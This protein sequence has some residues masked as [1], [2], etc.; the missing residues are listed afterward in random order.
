MEFLLAILGVGA[1]A[2]GLI[3][4]RYGSLVVGCTI[5]ILFG[6]VFTRDFWQL[7]F[8]PLPLT[9]DRLLIAGLAVLFAWRW[10]RGGIQ[11]RPLTGAD[12]LAAL[13]VGY[14]TVRCVLTE[15]AG[16]V[17]SSVSPSW[18]LIASFL[19][20]AALY[21]IV[22]N[23]E[24]EEK[25]WKWLL[26]G[27]SILGLYL[28]FTGIAEV[29]QQWWAVF[30]SF[31]SDPKL[32]TH[33]G[34]A[35]GP[36]LMSASLGV[37]LAVCFWASWFLWS[38]VNRWWRVL[39]S[40]SMLLMCAALYYTY[41][42]SC[43][44]GL[45]AGLA[46]VPLLHFP[47]SWRP[48]VLA[49]LIIGVGFGGMFVGSKV[50]NMGRKDADGDAEHSVYQRASFIYVSMRMFRDDPVFGCGF[51]RFYDK[52]MP[53]LSDRSQQI[54]LESI[55]KLD[56]HNTFLSILTETGIVGFTL[57]LATLVAWTRAAWQLVANPRSPRWVRNHG[58]FALAILIVY[59]VNALFHDLTLSPSEQWILCLIS[60][61]AVGLQSMSR[62]AIASEAKL[63][64]IVRI[65]EPRGIKLALQPAG[66]RMLKQVSLFGMKIHAVE[67]NTAV[68][69]VLSWCHEPAK[70]AC[71]YVV[72]PNVDHTVM[73]QTRAD[74][75]HAYAGAA[76]VLADGAPV[77]WASRL[78]R[79]PLPERVAGSDLVPA[80]FDAANQNSE[81]PL[82]VFLLG[83][84]SGVG[85]RAA[86]AIHQR[87]QNVEVVGT[88]SP[89]LGFENNPAE[90]QRILA[91]IAA[92]QPHLLLIGLGAP[93][94]E[95]WVRR[96]ADQLQAQAALCVGATIDFL[97]GEKSRSPH[98]MRCVGLEW[99]HR[100]LTEPSRLTKRYL[101]DAWIFP[102]LVWREW[103][104]I[105]T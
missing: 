82:R 36:V 102:Q 105:R 48:A 47:K 27:L 4:A 12:L 100:L 6:Y 75:R 95:L 55:R 69:T 42:R 78:L 98:W 24:L 89:P 28:A 10:W 7:D 56:H 23:A 45:A 76:L 65:E 93:K 52:K 68:E 57:F 61:I 77:V 41:T 15:P 51:G 90:N 67:M 104:G 38:Q 99:L 53:Y 22:R 79:R 34:R 1:L 21:W 86:R 92:T 83:A 71:R 46:I 91:L 37:Y 11:I 58:L 70:A 49:G 74:L 60:G 103:R 96:H 8:G 13:L 80:L 30:P 18:R 39:L 5:F 88:Y 64:A 31:I 43:W 29:K 20:P 84:A 85:E 94:Q 9:L 73:F 72:T 32:G 26:T 14:L 81:N 63:P 101:H 33:F 2:W 44:L 59:T 54:E 16:S 3:Y 40:G 87:W 25:Q 19:M 50:V 97:A 35:R 17:A 62:T 66:Q